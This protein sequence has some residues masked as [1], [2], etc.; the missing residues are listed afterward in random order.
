MWD[1]G[2][3]LPRVPSLGKL[4]SHVSH[5]FLGP[6]GQHKH[7][8]LLAVAGMQKSISNNTDAFSNLC[9]FHTC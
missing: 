5:P 2:F 3:C 6:A 7:V 9:L 1:S 4:C 8:L